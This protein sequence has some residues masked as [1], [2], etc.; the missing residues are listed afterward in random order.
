MNPYGPRR[1]IAVAKQI[2]YQQLKALLLRRIDQAVKAGGFYVPPEFRQLCKYIILNIQTFLTK[3]DSQTGL[4]DQ[5]MK[6]T[7]RS[8]GIHS[9]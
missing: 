8:L 1:F 2:E 5:L 9:N 4:P 6:D 7:G 3:I